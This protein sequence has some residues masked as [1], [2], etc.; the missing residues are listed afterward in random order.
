[1]A[2]K[3]IFMNIAKSISV[4]YYSPLYTHK[5]LMY[6]NPVAQCLILDTRPAAALIKMEDVM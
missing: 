3:N 6:K 5:L 4:C 1:M 2:F